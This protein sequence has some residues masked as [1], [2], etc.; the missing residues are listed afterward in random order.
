MEFGRTVTKSNPPLKPAGDAGIPPEPRRAQDSNGAPPASEALRKVVFFGCPLDCDE[1]EEAVRQK[2]ILM[3]PSRG[4]DDPYAAIMSFVRRGML[5]GCWE[6]RGSLDVPTW[7][8]PVPGTEDNGRVSVEEMV[9]FIDAGGCSQ[10]STQIGD[11]VAAIFPR[12]PCLIGVDHSLTGGAYRKLAELYA[13]DEITLLVVDSHTDALPVP[14]LAGAIGYDMETNPASVYDPDDPF[15]KGRP[16]SY[17]ASSFLHH[18]IEEG[19]LQPRNLL[20]LGAGDYP[21]K[22]AFR[23]KDRRIQQYAGAFERLKRS[24]ARVVTKKDILTAPTKV[25]KILNDVRTPYVYI[26]VDM[27]IGAR[28]AL[29][30]VRFQDRQ[31]LN[32]QQI[33]TLAAGIGAMLHRGVRLAGMDLLEIDGRLLARDESTEGDRTAAIAWNLIRL[34]CPGVDKSAPP[35]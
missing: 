3:G 20:I 12:I 10:F 23:I 29:R 33:Y 25:R 4:D 24:G 21:P 16:D 35:A 19:T 9:R 7:L 15:L 18:L 27:D 13:P 22:K 2:R 30:A 11:V 5:P 17:N 32:E 8:R 26:S 34:I 14:L 1:R 28:N 31:G 6:E